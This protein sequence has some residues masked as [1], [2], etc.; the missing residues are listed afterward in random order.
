MPQ[1][2]WPD[3]AL[4]DLATRRDALRQAAGLPGADPRA[5]IGAALTELDGAIEALSAVTPA[6]A[7][8][9]DDP[10]SDGLP[11]AVRAERR[12]LHAAFQQ[13]PAAPFLLDGQRPS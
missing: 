10:Q 7:A 9:R 3:G 5:L 6:G 12:V 13:A 2:R 8:D 1:G 11:E 4:A